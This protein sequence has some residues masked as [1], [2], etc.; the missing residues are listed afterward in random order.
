MG[1]AQTLLLYSTLNLIFTS[2]M[3]PK[4]ISEQRALFHLCRS[5]ISLE[6]RIAVRNKLRT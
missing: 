2:S 5:D 6:P 1:S 4:P 3:S